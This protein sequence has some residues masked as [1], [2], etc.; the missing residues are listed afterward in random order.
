MVRI[1]GEPCALF[2]PGTSHVR[3]SWRVIYRCKCTYIVI[4]VSVGQNKRLKRVNNTF[5]FRPNN[6]FTESA[7]LSDSVRVRSLWVEGAIHVFVHLRVGQVPQRVHSDQNSTLIDK[8]KGRRS[9]STGMEEGIKGR[10]LSQAS[11]NALY[12]CRHSLLGRR[13]TTMCHPSKAT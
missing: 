3:F 1:G 4:F 7:H 5:I 2:F 13:T 12:A 10:C 11:R 9:R 6:G 8:V